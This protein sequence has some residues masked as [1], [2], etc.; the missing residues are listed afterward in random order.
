M[1]RV[2]I[3]DIAG[4]MEEIGKID[5]ITGANRPACSFNAAIRPPVQEA[6]LGLQWWQTRLVHGMSLEICRKC[7][8]IIRTLRKSHIQ[9]LNP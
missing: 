9:Y 2:G 8:H 5:V 6:G 7:A 3:T 1:R 4:Q